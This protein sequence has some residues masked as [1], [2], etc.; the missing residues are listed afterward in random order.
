MIETP[1]FIQG[2][3]SY[4]GAGLGRP[5]PLDP[6]ATHRVPFDKRAQLIYLR[7][8]N[9]ASELVCLFLLRGKQTLRLFP[10]GAKSAVHVPLAIIEDLEPESELELRVG[11]PE[12]LEGVIVVDMGL[13]EI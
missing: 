13:M 1:R 11:G 4:R 5:A 2:V 12:G 10:V 8:G 3:F 7:A 6:A 9:A